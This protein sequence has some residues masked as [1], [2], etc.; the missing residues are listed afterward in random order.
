MQIILSE[1]IGKT[2]FLEFLNITGLKNV[3]FNEFVIYRKKALDLLSELSD[4]NLRLII[5]NAIEDADE[6]KIIKCYD[7]GLLVN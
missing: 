4:V 1:K 7:N 2:D 3:G 6:I 5:S